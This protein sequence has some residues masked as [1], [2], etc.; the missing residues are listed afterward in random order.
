M[1]VEAQAEMHRHG[2][3]IPPAS[4]FARL[5]AGFFLVMSEDVRGCELASQA[6]FCEEVTRWPTCPVW[7]S[8]VPSDANRLPIDVTGSDK[9]NAKPDTKPDAKLSGSQSGS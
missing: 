7:P 1:H 6:S 9:Q 5:L 3:S 2:G 8:S 4:T